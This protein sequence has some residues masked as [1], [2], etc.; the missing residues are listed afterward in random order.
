MR[1]CARARAGSAL[2]IALMGVLVLELAVAGVLYVATQEV[3]IA[4]AYAQRLRARSAAE[5]GVNTA[6]ARWPADSL[7]VLPEGGVYRFAAANGQLRGG[8]SFAAE[9]ERLRG[10]WFLVRGEGR[11]VA[12][13]PPAANAA[14]LISM[15][16]T[17]SL[18]RD[19]PAA[20][21]AAGDVDVGPAA[22]ID[23]L[24][25][26]AVPPPWNATTCP[27]IAPADALA[28]LGALN[29]PALGASPAS[30]VSIDPA[31]LLVGVPAI[32]R[33]SALSPTPGAERIG[34]LDLGAVA[35]GADRIE[36]GVL[37]LTPASAGANCN[38]GAASN[39][40]DPSD[41]A[42]PCADYVPLIYAPGDLEVTSGAGQGLLVVRG[43]LRLATGTRFVGAILALGGAEVQGSIV[44]ALRTGTGTS[45]ISGDIDY[46]VCA[47]WRAF[48]RAGPFRR[49]HRRG[50]R[51]WLPA[52]Q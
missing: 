43:R 11:T 49:P 1:D 25:A 5:S 3:L 22:R 52:F 26:D 13:G 9:I 48:T 47:L 50:D 38:T 44:G 19:F 6:L 2:V 14:A 45:N 32:Q 17:E 23:A 42:S 39:W 12:G 41:P 10:R 27:A 20:V 24:R 21:V 8:A 18:W 36:S 33:D 40:G 34:P 31:A 29:R 15:L 51:W 4:R 7:R 16:E 35:S 30:N 46:N 28:A 37:Q